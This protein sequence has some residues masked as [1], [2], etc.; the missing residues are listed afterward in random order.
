[1]IYF[2]FN[3]KKGSKKGYMEIAENFYLETHMRCAR[4]IHLSLLMIICLNVGFSFLSFF[5]F[6][7]YLFY[8]FFNFIK[9]LVFIFMF[10]RSFFVFSSA[11]IFFGDLI[12]SLLHLF[13]NSHLYFLKFTPILT[14][15]NFI[16]L[17]KKF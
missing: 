15:Y 17:E 12:K 3:N 11:N 2:F 10:F 9:F 4:S 13:S 14:F 1:M 6:C 5:N 7:F 16:Y 8:T